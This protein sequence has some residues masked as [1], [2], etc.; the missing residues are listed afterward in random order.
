[1]RIPPLTFCM[2]VALG[3]VACGGDQQEEISPGGAGG[4]SG[5]P[6]ATGAGQ[7]GSGT[8]G[9]PGAG[10]APGGAGAAGPGGTTGYRPGVAAAGWTPG[11][12][13][14]SNPGGMCTSHGG[15]PMKLPVTGVD[16]CIK[17]SP[18]C[19]TAGAQCP[20]YVSL[21]LDGAFFPYL[22][23]PANGPMI[24]VEL[25]C[26][27]DGDKIKDKLAELPRVIATDYAGLDRQRIYAIGWSAGAGGVTRGLCHISKK[28]DFSTLGTT[29]DLYAAVVAL[30]GCGCSGDYVQLAGSWH[31]ITWN[32]MKDPFN[33]GDACEKGLRE[34]A[35]V[36]GCSQLDAAW[37]PVP[38]SDAYA[39]NADGSSNAER[40]D[41]GTC[42]LGG[43]TGY[44]FKDEGHV[45]SAK[46]H[47]NPKIGGVD[48]V[49]RFLQGRTK[50]NG[51]NP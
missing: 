3:V 18:E 46:S 23:D 36:N 49:W 13:G 12:P 29:S 44:R 22:D 4:T 33:G 21:N 6:G 50:N 24:A 40:L 25:Y 27:T 45:L 17:A 20:L 9:A 31:I 5:A 41:F 7:G 11:S 15:T 26:E 43:V 30:G 32:G 37:T 28:S 10:G 39:K 2:A 34:R 48:T 51:G 8:A 42:Q 19:S 1:M 14:V 16:Y 35:I 38:A 47:F